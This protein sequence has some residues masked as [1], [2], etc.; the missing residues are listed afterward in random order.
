MGVLKNMSDYAKPAKNSPRAHLQNLEE[1]L[2]DANIM[3][4]D[5]WTND[6]IR[7]N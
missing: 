4:K 7:E 2:G 1:G 5:R 6:P 3:K